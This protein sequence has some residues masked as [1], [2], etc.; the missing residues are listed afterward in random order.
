MNDNDLLRH[1]LA[2]L[3]YRGNKAVRD[4]PETFAEFRASAVGRTSVQIL[5]HIGDLFDWALSIAEGQQRWRNASPL[6]WDREVARFHAA[7]QAFDEYLASGK[8]LH[9]SAEKLFQGPIA[10]A[11]THVGQLAMLRRLAGAPIKGE[12]Y[13]VAD[14]A[15]GRIGAEQA[16]ANREFD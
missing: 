2:T 9:A 3:A 16:R 11:F 5:A 7:L 6:P 15:T 14:I 1:T 13:F 8:P 10:D 4:A 12:N